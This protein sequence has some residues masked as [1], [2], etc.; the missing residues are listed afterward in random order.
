[1]NDYV[2]LT[3]DYIREADL[4]KVHEKIIVAR[5][6]DLEESIKDVSTKIVKYE[7]NPGGSSELTAVEAETEKRLNWEKELKQCADELKDLRRHINRIHESLAGL[8][9]EER[10][11]LRLHYR[12]GATYDEISDLMGWSPSTCKRR[13]RKAIDDVTLMLFGDKM[14]GNYRFID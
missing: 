9:T 1:M 3:K 11:M 6:E 8:N 5:M 10:E 2:R 4:Y 14:R 12:V 7:Q 13:V